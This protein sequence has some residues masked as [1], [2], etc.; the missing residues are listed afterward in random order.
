MSTQL[1]MPSR[2]PANQGLPAVAAGSPTFKVLGV[3]VDAVQIPEAIARV[4][5]WIAERGPSRY[6]AVTGMH[7]ITE[8]RHDAH[9]RRI[10]DA[11]DL[12]VGI[13]PRFRDPVHS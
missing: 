6:V 7:G 4:E 12:V 8:S 9:F 5:G 11:A 13:M 3:R 1:N 10:L 2:P